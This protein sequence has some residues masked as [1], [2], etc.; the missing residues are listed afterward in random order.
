MFC[1]IFLLSF[2]KMLKTQDPVEN[3]QTAK[4]R[5]GAREYHQSVPNLHY[6]GLH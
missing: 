3:E 4:G 1:E 5:V 2:A 6:C